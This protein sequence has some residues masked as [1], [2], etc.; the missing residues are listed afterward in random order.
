MAVNRANNGPLE[1]GFHIPILEPLLLNSGL[2]S[3]TRISVYLCATCELMTSSVDKSQSNNK[4][5]AL[6][7][8]K[9]PTSC[10]LCVFVTHFLSGVRQTKELKSR[11]SWGWERDMAPESESESESEARD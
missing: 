4:V 2:R 5:S 6:I 7:S 10:V 11:C 9:L 1:S 3:Y 8:W